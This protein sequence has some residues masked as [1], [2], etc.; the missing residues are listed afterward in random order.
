MSA[1]P[2]ILIVRLSSLGD[3]LHTLPAFADLRATYPESKIDWLVSHKHRFLVSAVCGID[4]IRVLESAPGLPRLI[5]DLRRQRYDYAIDF[6]GLLKSATLTRMSGARARV[7]Q[8]ANAP[9]PA[10]PAAMSNPAPEAGSR[11]N[12]YM[13]D[14]SE[15]P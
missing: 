12:P 1:S 8:N 2:G 10:A 6:Q 5:G 11:A 13:S 4:A 9:M 7:S 3:I 14:A 15:T